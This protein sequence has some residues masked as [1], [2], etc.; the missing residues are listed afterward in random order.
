MN[1]LVLSALPVWLRRRP[2]PVTRLAAAML[3]VAGVGGNRRQPLATASY[4]RQLRDRLTAVDESAERD[5]LLAHWTRWR[6]RAGDMSLA[7]GSWHGDWTPWNM[8]ST[9]AGLLLWDWERFTEGVPLGFD[10]L[11]YR[12]QQG[13]GAGASRAARRGRQLH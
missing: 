7:M 8:A 12:L 5:A 10:A 2:V 4:W 1:V 11:H 9:S 6:A 3:S 13:R